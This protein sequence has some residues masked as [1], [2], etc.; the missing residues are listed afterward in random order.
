MHVDVCVY[1]KVASVHSVFD[2]KRES[3]G[4]AGGAL[5]AF[6]FGRKER[7]ERIKMDVRRRGCFCRR[8]NFEAF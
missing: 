4:D 1:R 3:F 8:K 5:G 6:H 7:A 2:S